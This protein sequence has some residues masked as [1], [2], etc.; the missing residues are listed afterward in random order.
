[1]SRLGVSHVP[2]ERIKFGIV[3]NLFVYENSVLKSHHGRPF[4]DVVFLHYDRIKDH[5]EHIIEGFNVSAPSIDSPMKNLSG[6]NIQKLIIG[7]EITSD[8]SLLVASHPTYG[9]DVGATEYI[10][11]QLLKRRD[12]GGS[13]LLVS[14]DLEE[15]FSL[16]DRVAVIFQGRFMGIA[17]TADLTSESVGLMMAGCGCAEA[18]SCE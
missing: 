5:A 6:G 3:P 14:E 13:V 17:D 18:T 10:R 1:V 2:E 9:L 11:M 15:I 4:S 7:R 12:A 8:P 16:C